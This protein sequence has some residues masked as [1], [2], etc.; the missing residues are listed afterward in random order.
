[1]KR[2]IALFAAFLFS[3]SLCA[4]ESTFDLD[5]LSHDDLESLYYQIGSKLWGEKISSEKGARLLIGDYVIG[6]DILPGSYVIAVPNDCENSDKVF[7]GVYESIDADSKQIMFR[8]VDVNE[9]PYLIL[10]DLEDGN[11]IYMYTY[12]KDPELRIY[13]KSVYMANLD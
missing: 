12:G 11:Y 9:N 13:T 10:T 5:S 4:A 3:V 1:M 6:Q 2:F 7:I 8:S